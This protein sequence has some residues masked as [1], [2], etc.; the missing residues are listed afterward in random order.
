MIFKTTFCLG[1]FA[2]RSFWEELESE[3]CIVRLG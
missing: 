1:L 2:R 3:F